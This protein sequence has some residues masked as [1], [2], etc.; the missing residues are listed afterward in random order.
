MTGSL[1]LED[2]VTALEDRFERLD[3]ERRA[4]L[5]TPAVDE[6]LRL[7]A[8]EFSIAPLDI[9]SHRRDID[10]TAARWLVCWLARRLTA[11][12]YPQIGRALGRDHTTIMSA[13]RK[14]DDRRASDPAY[15]RMTERLL[16]QARCL[17][18]DP[19]GL[20]G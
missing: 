9:R 18:A 2:R 15:T 3:G 19:E 12:S 11:Y 6:L 8:D 10:T 20:D 7:V 16:D 1:S 17:L 13:V 4:R 14:V 5:H